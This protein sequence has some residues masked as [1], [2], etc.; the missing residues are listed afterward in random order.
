MVLVPT[1]FTVNI[2]RQLA[3]V[4]PYGQVRTYDTYGGHTVLYNV[5]V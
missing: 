5:M 3:A 4:Q 2:K 1:Y